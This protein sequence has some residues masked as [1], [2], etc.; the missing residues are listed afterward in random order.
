MNF[1][2]TLSHLQDVGEGGFSLLVERPAARGNSLLGKVADRYI[3]CF[4]HC[5]LVRM[6]QAG[7]CSKERGLARS[8]GT[9]QPD[10]VVRTNS[11]GNILEQGTV[12]E[13]DGDVLEGKH[14][15]NIRRGEERRKDEE[16]LLPADVQRTPVDHGLKSSVLPLK[17]RAAE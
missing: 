15:S 3:A 5:P 10:T 6:M 4:L 8:V 16:R 9:D 12:A 13:K 17:D 2:E 7:D 1:R 11:K 14:E